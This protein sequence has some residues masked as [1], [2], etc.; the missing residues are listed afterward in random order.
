MG[1]YAHGNE[2]S[3]NFA[4]LYHFLGKSHKSQDIIDNVIK[5]F[6]TNIATHI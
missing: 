5:N 4:Y 3:H 1:Q 6:Y 2:P